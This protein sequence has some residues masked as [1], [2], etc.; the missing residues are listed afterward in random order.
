MSNPTPEKRQTLLQKLAKMSV[1]QRVQFAMKGGS[2]ARRTLIRDSKQSG[3]T[4]GA[5][6]TAPDGSGGSSIRGNAEFTDE[7]CGLIG[8]QPC[9][10]QELYTMWFAT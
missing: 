3:A 1:S 7:I 6:I 8:Q 10:P 9:A 5:A 2:E 4:R